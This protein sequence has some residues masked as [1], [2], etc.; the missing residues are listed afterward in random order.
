MDHILQ[1]IAGSQ[2]MSMLDGFS[3]YNQIM[4]HPYDQ[5]KTTFTTPWGT[6]MYAKIPFRLMNAGEIF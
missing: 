6:L 2:R 5:E 4:V 1:N 3:G